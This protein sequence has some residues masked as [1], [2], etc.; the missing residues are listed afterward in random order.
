MKDFKLKRIGISVFYLLAMQAFGHDS[1]NWN[2]DGT[3]TN[4][5]NHSVQL[6][7]ENIYSG[8]AVRGGL[9]VIGFDIDADRINHPAVAWVSDDLEDIKHWNF[10]NILES[11]F[12]YRDNVYLSDT[13]GIVYLWGNSGWSVADIKLEPSSK[14]IDSRDDII[15]CYPSSPF[16]DPAKMGGCFSVEQK[17]QISTHWL[18]L[19]SEIPPKVCDQYL[20]IFERA[21]KNKIKKIRKIDITNGNEMN[22]W[23]V[24]N[25]PE[26]LCS[27]ELL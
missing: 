20:Y 1:L 22:T 26:D 25:E 14:V 21:G 5:E 17:W 12:Q 18:D 11:I 23:T 7:L 2:Y 15:A 16:K 10:E 19:T 27:V 9:L 3:I 8:L 24:D 4:L 13:N 6:E